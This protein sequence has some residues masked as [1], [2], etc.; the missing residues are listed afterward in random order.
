MSAAV[1]M[2]RLAFLLVVGSVTAL[3][4]A[5]AAVRPRYGGTLR[6]EMRAAVQSLASAAA[7]QN[8]A[9][10][11]RLAALIF[12]PLVTLD[13]NG[14]PRAAL[15]F[16][17]QHTP[18]YKLWQLWL[19]PAKF[20]DGSPVTPSQVIASLAAANPNAAWRAR[21]DGDS[22]V[23]DSDV[24]LPNL[25]LQ[26]AQQKNAIVLRAR[27]GDAVGSGPFR[28]SQW[29]PG[30][31]AVLTANEE[32]WN[33]RPFLDALE[34]M[35]DRPL[36]EQMIDMELG[37]ADVVE[38]AIDQVRRAAQQGRRILTSAPVELFVLTFNQDRRA[39]QDPKLRE[40][41][42]LSIDRKAVHEVLLQRQGE[43]AGGLLPQWISGYALLF[44][45]QPNLERARQ[46]RN[47]VLI[48]SL[49]LNYDYSDPL[50]RSIAERIALNAREAGLSVQ[51]IG[52]N[53]SVRKVADMSLMRVRLVSADAA[54]ALAGL[55]AQLPLAAHMSLAVSPEQIYRAEAAALESF[56]VVP[57]AAIPEAY[58]VSSRVRNWSEPRIGGWPLPWGEVW[59]ENKIE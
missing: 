42:A 22:I 55:A 16:S 57:I 17:W 45:S 3:V 1:N 59:V 32:Y 9:A 49:T 11:E 40:A 7:E 39:V 48:T 26:L 50:A 37:N 24:P 47:E 13:Q 46:L 15:A 21:V 5:H 30:R 14:Q 53:L 51:A 44:S 23:F 19:R 2:K 35:M 20:H 54:T 6:V 28:V 58:G 8:S 56:A 38:V 52:E 31:R 27:N 25:P 18:D 36:R 4:C 29:Q 34:I 12:E 41:L 33:G 10:Q 43:P